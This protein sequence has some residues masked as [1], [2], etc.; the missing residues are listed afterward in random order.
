MAN[1]NTMMKLTGGA[2]SFI[3][4]V[5]LLRKFDNQGNQYAGI[6]RNVIKSGDEVKLS[7]EYEPGRV[8]EFAME[9]V[10]NITDDI[11]ENSKY[12]NDLL[13]AVSLIGKNVLMNDGNEK[14]TGVVKGVVRNGLGVSI[15]VTIIK[16]GKEQDIYVPFEY[17]TNVQ[18]DGDFGDIEKPDENPDE[19][20]VDP[21]DPSDPS[22]PVDP[23]DPSDGDENKNEVEEKK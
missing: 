7:I 8:G 22:N 11:N 9:D 1:L 12:N 6:V 5:V 4:K 13:N 19:K 20:P 16:D 14:I 3:G 17:V 23:S 18:E 15:K 10:L 2:S 21:S